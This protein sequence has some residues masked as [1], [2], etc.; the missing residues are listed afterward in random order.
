[1]IVPTEASIVTVIPVTT[2]VLLQRSV[3][4]N[5]A[6]GVERPVTDRA[7]GMLVTGVKGEGRLSITHKGV[8]GAWITVATL[9]QTCSCFTVALPK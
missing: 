5:R 7:Q 3:T 4:D 8:T 1:M 2:L 6:L 9:L